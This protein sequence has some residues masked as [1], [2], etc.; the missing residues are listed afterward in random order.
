M[1]ICELS[2]ARIVFDKHYCPMCSLLIEYRKLVTVRDCAKTL[3]WSQNRL[4]K[5]YWDNLQ[6]SIIHTKG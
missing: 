1:E 5:E 6:E 4:V 3:M 2:H